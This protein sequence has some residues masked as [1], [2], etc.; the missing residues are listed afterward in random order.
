MLIFPK[1]NGYL[2][3]L[4]DFGEATKQLVT[5][6][7]VSMSLTAEF[8][9]KEVKGTTPFLSP[10]RFEDPKMPFTTQ[11][12]IF[13]LG[14]IM[15]EI[16]HPHLSY[17]WE[18]VFP[19]TT[20]IHELIKEKI[21]E[22]ERP[23]LNNPDIT[24]VLSIETDGFLTTVMRQY[25]SLMEECWSQD[26]NV[27]PSINKILDLVSHMNISLFGDNIFEGLE[28]KGKKLY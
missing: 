26:P 16:L 6:L 10:E 8:R 23:P 18:E 24:K 19:E 3:K 13:A 1:E 27:R 7:T 15:H 9:T 5:A 2:F 21:K 11:Q 12:D 28:S 25:I 17:P 20:T 4:C 22:G 14:I